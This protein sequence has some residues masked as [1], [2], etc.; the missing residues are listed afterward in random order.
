MESKISELI[1]FM[2]ENR[3]QFL[4]GQNNNGIKTADFTIKSQ[5]LHV[6]ME[7]ESNDLL[8]GMK[9]IFQEDK[10]DKTMQK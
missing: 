7:M 9:F 1:N 4:I 5:S 2:R 10:D 8:N 6:E 3:I